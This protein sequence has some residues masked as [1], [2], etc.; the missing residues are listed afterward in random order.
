MKNKIFIV[1]ILTM[2]SAICFSQQSNHKINFIEFSFRHTL[3][4]PNNKVTVSLVKR[5]SKILVMVNSKPMNNENKWEK[6]KIDTTFTIDKKVFEELTNEVLALE[7][8]S[9]NRAI[10]QE[11]IDGTQCVIEYGADGCSL[12]YKF[13]TPNYDTAQRGLTDFLR[14]CKKI[15]EIGGLKPTDIL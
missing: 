10:V 8:T 15:I 5:P 7:N 4:I 13:W 2:I 14:L 3:R 12:T 6:T 11:C 1:L 9:L